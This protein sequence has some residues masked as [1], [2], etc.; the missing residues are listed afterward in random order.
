MDQLRIYLRQMSIY[1]GTHLP[2]FERAYSPCSDYSVLENSTVCLTSWVCWRTLRSAL[3]AGCRNM[4]AIESLRTRPV[5]LLFLYHFSMTLFRSKIGYDGGGKHCVACVNFQEL[6]GFSV[7]FA[8]DS[9]CINLKWTRN[10][11]IWLI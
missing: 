5:W 7:E 1:V 8:V 9:H 2:V 10:R 11:T 6:L 4:L 3:Q